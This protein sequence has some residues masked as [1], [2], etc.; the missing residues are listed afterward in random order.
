[1]ATY[2]D[3]N[4]LRTLVDCFTD[5][6]NELQDQL[7]AQKLGN[8][9]GTISLSSS[10][11][12]DYGT[13]ISVGI[14]S[15]DYALSADN[16]LKVNLAISSANTSNTVISKYFSSVKENIKEVYLLYGTGS[17]S[18]AS[19]CDTS[20]FTNVYGAVPVYKDS[21][22]AKCYLGTT[23]DT[24]SSTSLSLT[25]YTN[26]SSED[27][28]S[29]SDGNELTY[30]STAKDALCFVYLLADGTYSLVA[31]D[32]EDFL[33]EHEF[34]DGLQVSSSIVSVKINSN[35]ASSKYLSVTSSGVGL[36]LGSV[37]SST[38]PVYLKSGAITK[39]S[40]TVGSSNTIVYVSSG[41]LTAGT[42]FTAI[43]SSSITALFESDDE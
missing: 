37:G 6:T 31:V 10:S 19:E 39:F 1:M 36:D 41:K 14:S 9:D 4:G 15:Q 40:A 21:S 38:T 25:R 26:I 34:G 13:K 29:D 3:Y 28:T 27:G 23:S 30:S 42:S 5:I 43:S 20:S 32:V 11:N 22:L 2:L 18:S 24:C 7:D 12:S 16:G 35:S 8:V 33:R 17:N